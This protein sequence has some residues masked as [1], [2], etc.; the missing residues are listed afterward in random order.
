MGKR[1]NIPDG[2]RVKVVSVSGTVR[3]QSDDRTDMEVEPDDRRVVYSDDGRVVEVKSKSTNVDI[4]V[5]V[6]CNVQ[7]GTVSGNVEMLGKFGRV[8]ASSVSGHVRVGDTNGDAD[9]RSI[10]G[11]IEVGDCGGR[12][13]AN[14]KSGHIELAHVASALQAHTMS[15]S[16]EVGTAGEQD[17]EI[18]SI[19]GRVTVK[20]D[21]GKAPR[22]KLR[23]LSGR[24]NNGCPQGTDFELK[25]STISGSIE[26]QEG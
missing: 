22:A 13:R 18:K 15:G 2:A 20:V 7:V 9:I 17:V 12:C 6:G 23:T 11:H 10:S 16:I 24:V 1:Y 19:S 26:V 21:T 8:T 4:R 3:V 25:A 14:T 5:P